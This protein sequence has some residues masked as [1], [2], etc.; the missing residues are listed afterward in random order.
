MVNLSIYDIADFAPG[1]SKVIER[2]RRYVQSPGKDCFAVRVTVATLTRLGIPQGALVVLQQPKLE[3]YD[4]RTRLLVSRTDGVF[5][6]TGVDWTLA[7]VKRLTDNDGERMQISY[8][9]PEADF[10]PERL[11][12]EDLHVLGAVVEVFQD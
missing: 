8:A 2:L 10:R 5:K 1:K 9:R 3:D 4:G 12:S 11:R 7:H 6:L